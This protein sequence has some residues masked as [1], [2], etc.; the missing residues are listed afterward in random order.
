M[1]IG[2][3]A[4]VQHPLRTGDPLGHALHFGRTC[5]ERGG[6]GVASRL[7]DDDTDRHRDKIGPN[8]VA[9]ALLVL[10]PSAFAVDQVVE[11]RHRRIEAAGDLAGDVLRELRLGEDHKVVAADVAGEMP[12]RRVLLQDLENDRGERL[13]DIV[14]AH[15]AVVIVVALEGVDVGVQDR[16][17]LLANQTVGDLAKDVGVPTHARQRVELARGGGARDDRAQASDQLFGNEGFGHIIVG[18]VEKMLDFVFERAAHGQ[19]DDGDQSGAEVFAQLGQDRFASRRAEHE[20]EHDDVWAPVDSGVVRGIAVPDSDTFEAG[21]LE[22]ALDELQHLLA[23]VDY[24]DEVT[25]GLRRLRRRRFGGLGTSDRSHDVSAGWASWA[26]ATAVR[27]RLS[28]SVSSRAR[29]AAVRIST[30]SALTASGSLIS[31]ATSSQ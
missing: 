18:A 3:A 29:S 5:G 14:P 28:F 19:E 20:V 11:S 7:R 12:P 9:V 26:S 8:L 2:R 22:D 10:D 23:V 31:A 15:E 6:A 27:L 1:A 21:P 25:R 4:S 30:M 24:E 17:A 16:K 13:D